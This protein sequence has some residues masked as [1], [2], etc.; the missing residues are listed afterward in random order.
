MP[1][2]LGSSFAASVRMV[3][4]VHRGP[5]DVWP[6]TKPPVP[7]SLAD[8]NVHVL[9]I[10][11]NADRCP[12]GRRNTPDLA[13]WQIDLGPIGVTGRQHCTR[14]RRTTKHAATAWLHLNIVDRHPQR[15]LKQR[16]AIAYRRCRPRTAIKRL[17]GLKSLGSQDITLLTILVVQKG[18]ARRAV[19]IVLNRVDQRGNPVLVATEVDQAVF[20]LVATAAMPSGNITLVV[21]PLERDLATNRC[22]GCLAPGVSSAKSLTVAP[23]RPGVVGL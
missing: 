2:S 5:T 1:P 14:P 15:D 8:H 20:P 6:P 16:K 4:G 12:A 7:T 11:D 18:D 9:G 10:A 23:R 19:G 21:A 22:L 17:P 3:Y 13:A